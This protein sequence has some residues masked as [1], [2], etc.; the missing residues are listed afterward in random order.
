MLLGILPVCVSFLW[1][2]PQAWACNK[3]DASGCV[4]QCLSNWQERSKRRKVTAMNVLGKGLSSRVSRKWIRQTE[5]H[6]I[7]CHFYLWHSPLLSALP[8][9]LSCLHFP[10][11]HFFIPTAE[12]QG[13]KK[14]SY[15]W[16]FIM[17]K[18]RI[19]GRPKAAMGIGW[20]SSSSRL[21]HGLPSPFKRNEGPLGF[22]AS[23]E[24][25]FELSIRG[26]WRAGGPWGPTLSRVS[27]SPGVLSLLTTSLPTGPP[28]GLLCS[29]GSS[30]KERP[31]S[32]LRDILCLLKDFIGHRESSMVIKYRH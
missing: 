12:N 32:Q 18:P 23:L 4:P 17:F 29:C 26:W 7:I 22:R 31:L 14:L 10:I 9:N 30:V 28:K 27:L 21:E 6:C 20:D 3:E 15:C 1:A 19:M 13:T 24:H 2:L 8:L 16:I 5:Y 11:L 25:T